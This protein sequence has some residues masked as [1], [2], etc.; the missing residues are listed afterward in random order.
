MGAATNLAVALRDL[1]DEAGA[2]QAILALV[3]RNPESAEAWFQV[4]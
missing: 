2:L 1:G 4:A 3:Q